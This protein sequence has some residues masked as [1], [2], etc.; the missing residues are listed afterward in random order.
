MN[1]I[2]R[3]PNTF[4]D[5]MAVDAARL[6]FNDRGDNHTPER[7]A[8]LIDYLVKH[9]HVNPFFHP[10]VSVSLDTRLPI[11][12]MVQNKPLMAGL[13][14]YYDGNKWIVTTSAWGLMALC[15]FFKCYHNIESMPAFSD[16]YNGFINDE[17]EHVEFEFTDPPQ[18]HQWF[19]FLFETDMCTKAQFYT[20]TVGLAKSS[21]SYRYIEPDCF[22]V[23]D[24]WRGKA[25]NVKQGSSDEVVAECNAYGS[26]EE[27]VNACLNWYD[28]NRHICNEQ[29][30][31]V[32][33]QAQ[34]SKYTIT[35]T[36]E[37]WE[38]VCRLRCAPD[39]QKE[40]RVLADVIQEELNKPWEH[41][42]C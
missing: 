15:Q 11:E 28:A 23:P 3:I 16:S 29:R 38:R 27:R 4:T 24:E 20:H 40:I 2:A 9:E 41:G 17:R 42:K 26:F 18:R 5:D 6:S 30:R 25:D 37:A 8:K 10:M 22:Y 31:L 21:Q 35:G 13:N 19:S 39:A 32:L 34:M 33:P 36:R 1:T 14:L 7:N 12:L